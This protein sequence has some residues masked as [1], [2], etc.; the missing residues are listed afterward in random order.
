MLRNNKP[1]PQ[2]RWEK[3]IQLIHLDIQDNLLGTE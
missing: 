2:N 1:S 3:A